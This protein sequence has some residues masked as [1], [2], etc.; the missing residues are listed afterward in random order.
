MDEP[1]DQVS[2]EEVRGAT[3]PQVLRGY[4]RGAVHAFLSK[5]ADRVENGANPVARAAPA[6]IKDEL[7]KVGQRTAGI[8][9]AAEDVAA[10][11]RDE[12]KEYGER[13]RAGAEDEARRALLG[14]SQ[15][16][17]EIVAAAEA[18]GNQIID[19]AIARRR[20]LNDAIAD[21]LDRRDEIANEAM[22]VADDLAA[23]VEALRSSNPDNDDGASEDKQEQEASSGA[24]ISSGADSKI[25]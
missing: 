19:E 13:L 10:N 21:L 16:A 24:G 8:L 6:A 22:R 9:T 12:A 23:A 4:D 3:F 2:G 15:K 17:D 18:R 25:G 11:L 7:A 14:A 20:D 1:T 5:I